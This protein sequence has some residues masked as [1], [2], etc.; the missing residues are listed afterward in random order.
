MPPT[1]RHPAV[2][3]AAVARPL[4]A[5][6]G[7]VA[8]LALA[9][10]G[11]ILA[12]E[13]AVVTF[14]GTFP[15]DAEPGTTVTL[16]W[17]LRVP[18]GEGGLHPWGGTPV[19]VR[20]E[21]PTGAATEAMGGAVAGVEGRYSAAVIVPAGGITAVEAFIRGDADGVRTDLPVAVDP[22][23][24]MAR[25][26]PGKVAGAPAAG[27]PA[28][29][30]PAAGAPTVAPAPAPAASPVPGTPAGALALIAVLAV[31]AVVAVVVLRRR[32]PRTTEA[33]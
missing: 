25:S 18:D 17:D 7:A 4:F 12:K 26:D 33:G 30:A 14:V 9:L 11:P 19:G 16:T 8:V 22:D 27:A 2:R 6:V 32:L 15:R 3:R 13:G 1:A 20:L 5:S 31:L 29:G 24:I 28:T 23:P 21:G 10:V